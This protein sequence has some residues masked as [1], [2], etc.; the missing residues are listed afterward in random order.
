MAARLVE[1][2][3]TGGTSGCVNLP[4]ISAPPVPR[5]HR[6]LHLHR[7]QP[8]VLAAVNAVFARRKINILGQALRTDEAMGYLV[9][10]V[11]RLTQRH[12][13]RRRRRVRRQPA[14]RGAVAGPAGRDSGREAGPPAA[15]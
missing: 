8:G 14:R 6:F 13:D 1:F 3:N 4:Q 7:N 12:R 2:V 5:A 9:P 11:D 15:R 10:D